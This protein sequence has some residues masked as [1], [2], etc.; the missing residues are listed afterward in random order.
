MTRG[1]EQSKPIFLAGLTLCHNTSLENVT[2]P[3]T[4]EHDPLALAQANNPKI[5][6][7]G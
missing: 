3:T 7:I 6:S 4:V 5:N 2:V 1:P